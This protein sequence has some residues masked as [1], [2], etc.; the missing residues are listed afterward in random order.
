MPLPD[1]EVTIF[2]AAAITVQRLGAEEQDAKVGDQYDNH[3]AQNHRAPE[4]PQQ[5][6]QGKGKGEHYNQSGDLR[7]QFSA[8][9]V[10]LAA[11]HASAEGSGVVASPVP[12]G[13][14][15]WATSHFKSAGHGGV[16]DSN[17]AAATP[18]RGQQ[19]CHSRR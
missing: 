1:R 19:Q 17:A 7:Q 14:D 4:V 5:A 8:V 16:F 18:C 12:I 9:H 15:V 6:E 3:D 2:R 10:L 11:Q 13:K